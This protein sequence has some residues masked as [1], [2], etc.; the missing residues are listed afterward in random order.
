M[1]IYPSTGE[2]RIMLPLGTNEVADLKHPHSA[3]NPDVGVPRNRLSMSSETKKGV[4][5]LMVKVVSTLNPQ[6][7]TP[8]VGVVVSSLP[9]TVD[10][11]SHLVV[12]MP[13]ILKTLYGFD[14]GASEW[15][16]IIYSQ[17][18]LVVAAAL[19]ERSITG[20]ATSVDVLPEQS[21]IMRA[22]AGMPL[23]DPATSVLG[24]AAALA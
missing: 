17:I 2:A 6:G 18:R 8:S 21:P 4:T 3:V 13:P 16:S 23:F 12:T 14:A 24:Q 5:R 7:L 19:A 11:T 22:L 1:T 15:T 10:I 20:S 9:E